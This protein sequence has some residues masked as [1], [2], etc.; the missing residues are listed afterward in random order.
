MLEQKH[1][2]YLDRYISPK[3]LDEKN[4]KEMKM[5]FDACQHVKQIRLENFLDQSFMKGVED[6]IRN[7]KREHDEFYTH[8]E[9][10]KK[11]T[12]S[13]ITWKYLSGLYTLFHSKAFYSYM[14]IFYETSV[15]T[16]IPVWFML[17]NILRSLMRTRG[18]LLQ[19]YNSWDYLSWHT[20]GPIQEVAGSFVF[21][22]N[23]EW[24]TSQWWAL[25]FW[26]KDNIQERDPKVYASVY[27]EYNTFVFFKCEKDVSWHR[28]QWVS[29]WERMTYHDQLFYK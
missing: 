12:G 22:L 9:G 18:S 10:Y 14:E 26:Y 13:Y 8:E 20:D 7:G 1:K 4:L 23:T 5:N 6:D 21:F 25:E 28:V 27:P 29:S 24:N 3:Y 2:K 15:S 16:P 19:I 11:G 17:E